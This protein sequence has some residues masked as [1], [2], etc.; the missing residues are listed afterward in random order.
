VHAKASR[1]TQ[2]E[3][4]YRQ[5]ATIWAS[6]G[7]NFP[8]YRE[9]PVAPILVIRM[10]E[11]LAEAQRADGR[12]AEAENSYRKALG[13]CGNPSLAKR[14]TRKALEV[15]C[16]CG[17]A[18]CLFAVGRIQEAEVLYARALQVDPKWDTVQI[19]Y[20]WFLATRPDAD[21]RDPG[22]AIKL[23][24]PLVE[25]PFGNA[26][27]SLVLGVAHYRAGDWK[28]AVTTL[29][30]SVQ[31]HEGLQNG[32][33]FFLAM[34]YW[35]LGEKN[36]AREQCEGAI[37]WT[38]QCRPKDPELLRF[39]AEAVRLL[40]LE[41]LEPAW[42][43]LR[44]DQLAA[45]ARHFSTAIAADPTLVEDPRVARR[46][47][48][49]AARAGCGQG[50][51]AALL[52]ARE[53]ARLRQHALAWLRTHLAQWARRLN[54][55]P[56]HVQAMRDDLVT[57][58]MSTLFACVRDRGALAKLPKAEREQWQEFWADIADKLAKA[59]GKPAPGQRSKR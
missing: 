46:A 8:A 14:P 48:A 9:A 20:A 42:L 54:S 37:Y 24:K 35:R 12:L 7:T 56:R 26:P 30:K 18:R 55:D 27:A 51:D 59:R 32:A 29:S 41:Q 13:I 15:E 23:V 44:K 50:K 19:E 28:A 49:C 4:A 36:R 10:H 25:P 52:E 38:D 34:A 17:L 45:A 22:R 47:A 33:G 40:G 31:Q 1:L 5:A 57:L 21:H 6:I 11:R 39:H 53:R 2:A 43:C 16:L 3:S 58:Q